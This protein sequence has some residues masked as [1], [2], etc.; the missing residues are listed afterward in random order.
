MWVPSPGGSHPEVTT[1]FVRLGL[2][3]LSRVPSAGTLYMGPSG[4]SNS[5]GRDRGIL[6]GEEVL[7]GANDPE[8]FLLELTPEPGGPIT[9]HGF[10]RGY[11]LLCVVHGFPA[12]KSFRPAAYPS[13][14]MTLYGRHWTA[15]R[16]RV[17]MRVNPS[18]GDGKSAHSPI[19]G[20]R[21]G[22]RGGASENPQ[23][24]TLGGAVIDGEALRALGLL[25][26]LAEPP[27]H[28]PPRARTASRSR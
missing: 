11:I 23:P 12:A 22:W 3:P 2:G 20:M 17:W 19:C 27:S 9:C 6:R 14:N 21:I 7:A 13:V 15:Q 26:R 25:D 8:R 1:P 16:G 28:R 5:F 24:Q 4:R 18:P 10:C